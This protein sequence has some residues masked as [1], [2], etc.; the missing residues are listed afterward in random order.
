MKE[1]QKVNK[2]FKD[3]VLIMKYLVGKIDKLNSSEAKEGRTNSYVKNNNDIVCEIYE[4]IEITEK[5]HE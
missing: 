2:D 4:H 5:G 1:L 3:F